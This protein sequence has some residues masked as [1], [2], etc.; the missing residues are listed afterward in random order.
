MKMLVTGAGGTVGRRL[1]ER[2]AAEGHAVTGWDRGA[3]PV[4]NEPAAEALLD[5]CRPD[6]LLH[7]AIAS[8]PTGMADEGERVNV[9]WPEQLSRLCAARDVRF[10]FTS[11]VMVFS[12]FQ[13]GPFE[14][15]TV[16]E[17]QLGYG[18]EKR[19]AE[20][21]VRASNPDA[22]I[23][24]LGWQIGEERGSNNMLDFLH[25]EQIRNG[26]IAASRGWLPACSFLDDTLDALV[27]VL[28]LPG[29]TYQVD[30]NPG[31]SFY[32][33]AAALNRRHGRPWTVTATDDFAYDQR[34]R[35]GRLACAS[36]AERLDAGRPASV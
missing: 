13:Q 16:P 5:A 3:A 22:R 25:N 12:D 35:D 20:E 1:T 24:R 29:G 10:V 2:L 27:R 32:D 14:P 23:V 7:L 31:W 30:G 26:A 21:R 11:T 18:G 8:R 28:A 15:E 6:A 17:A 4:L 33:I 9:A 34:M 19:R 36:I